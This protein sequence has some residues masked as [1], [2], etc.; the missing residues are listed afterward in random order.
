[1][2]HGCINKADC[3]ISC[4]IL[5]KG[6]PITT[7]EWS[8]PEHTFLY[9]NWIEEYDIA[10]LKETYKIENIEYKIVGTIK[11]DE[12][13]NIKECFKNSPVVKNKFKRLL[14]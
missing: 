13:N 11:P 10:L 7:D 6:R 9:G 2:D 5:Q 12:F 8:F 4:Y 1:M 14:A 3:G